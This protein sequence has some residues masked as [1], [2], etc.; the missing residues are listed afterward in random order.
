MSQTS[1]FVKTTQKRSSSLD[2]EAKRLLD[3][4]KETLKKGELTPC[5]Q[6]ASLVNINANKCP[7]CTSDISAHTK[8][9]R[10]ELRKLDE[11]T[12]KL[13]DLH[14]REI[15]VHRE[16]AGSKPFWL[17]F[18]EFFSEPQL[19]QDLKLVLP[20]LI[21]FFALTL[22]L[23]GKVSGLVFWIISLAG[24]FVVYNLFKKWNLKKYVTVDLYR[25][26]LVLGLIIVLLGSLGNSGG[27]WPDF[28]FAKASVEVQGSVAN[29]REAPTTNSAVVTTVQQGN[30]LKVIERSGDW[31]RVE[32]P[33]GKTGWLHANLVK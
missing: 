32:T 12:S 20:F 31:Y 26:I 21:G 15:E 24:G 17:R 7:H 33:S 11:I 23:N 25:S 14:Q 2:A 6:C 3:F 10:E 16:E 19:L 29:I 8:N 30:R 27:F 4:K 22:L 1:E 18:R 9:I 5:P 28:S 13:H